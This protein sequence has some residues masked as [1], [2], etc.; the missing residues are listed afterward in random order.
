MEEVKKVEDKKVD[1]NPQILEMQ[2]TMKELSSRLDQATTLISNKDKEIEEMRAASVKVV[3]D[4]LEKEKD[5]KA[6]FGI[7]E[8]KPARSKDDINALTNAEM[9]E[10]IA[11]VVDGS[12]NAHREEATN[13]METGFKNLDTK[14]DQVVGHI[15][16][17]EADIDLQ[18]VR[19]ANKDFDNYKDEMREVLKVHQEFS[20]E[21]A[22]DWVKMKEGK[23]EVSA[24][25]TESEKPDKDLGS[26]DEDVVRKKQQPTGRKLS[27]NQLFKLKLNE[28][29]DKVQSRR[30]GQK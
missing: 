4:K 28:A 13:E 15:L 12:L 16:K 1:T 23:G 26:A 17:K 6:K 21:D 22:Y 5:L 30:G 3:D 19:S 27:S 24:K 11:D 10:V 25:H 18:T 2:Q 9:F 20:I 29:I 14:F 8:A 7:T